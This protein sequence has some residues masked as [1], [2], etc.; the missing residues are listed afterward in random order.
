MRVALVAVVLCVL[1]RPVAADA[2]DEHVALGLSLGGTI[3]SWAMFAAGEYACRDQACGP[4]SVVA[5]VGLVGALGTFVAPSLGHWYDGHLVTRGLVMRGAGVGLMMLGVYEVVQTIGEDGNESAGAIGALLFFGG[6]ALYL[7]G[8]GTD[9][10][11][12]AA[13]VRAHDRSA[14][15]TLAPI[16]RGGLALVGRF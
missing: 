13:H 8:T 3:A 6:A 16:G 7:Y 4:S 11:S 10:G 5:W 15:V 12:A 14:A 9:I 1:A 2:Q